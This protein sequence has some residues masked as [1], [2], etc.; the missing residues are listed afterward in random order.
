MQEIQNERFKKMAWI[1]LALGCASGIIHY[2]Y[3]LGFLLGAGFSIFLFQRN[4]KF[5]NELVDRGNVKKTSGI[6]HSILNNL[7]MLG[8]LMLGVFFKQYL[9][10]IAIAVGLFFMKITYFLC[11]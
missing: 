11:E 3:A 4:V 6:L 7:M 2:S 10:V 8:V 9:N 1:V 5:W